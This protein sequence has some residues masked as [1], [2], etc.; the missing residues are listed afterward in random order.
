MSKL[1]AEISYP[2]MNH[3]TGWPW[4]ASQPV[5]SQLRDASASPRITVVTPSYNQAGTLEETIR[6]VVLQNY[7]NLE[8]LVIDGGSTDG[9]VEIIRKYEQ[10]ITY[11]VSEPDRGQ[12][13]AINKGWQRAT[14][15]LITWLNSD[16]YLAEGVLGRVANVYC[17]QMGRP[18]SFIYARA[19]IINNKYEIL[20]KIGEPFDLSFCL[21]NLIDQFPQPSVF[22]TKSSFDQV[23][24]VD[25]E[26]HYA[27]DFDLF[28]RAA[29]LVP[30]VFVDEIWSYVRFYPDTKTS[31]NPLG[32]V[33][34]HFRLL[35]KLQSQP[36]FA[37]KVNQYL[38]SA[39]AS[40]YLRSARL[41]YGAGQKRAALQD[42]SAAL[43]KDALFTM[44]KTVKIFFKGRYM[45]LK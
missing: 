2:V 34:D 25:E 30:P 19:N 29:L 18:T 1:L 42:L 6:S 9:S 22:L 45:E 28:L 39:Y 8:Y 23:G 40:N 5:P 16:D 37:E 44:Q 41:R 7:P 35:E 32:F 33:C 10:L 4:N 24:L 21:K 20:R 26:M 31:R 17:Q 13:H 12:S 11:W 36:R 3:R 14:G 27:M 43:Q 15:E 38:K